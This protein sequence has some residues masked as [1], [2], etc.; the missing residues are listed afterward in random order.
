MILAAL[1]VRIDRNSDPIRA[2]VFA[3]D[4]LVFLPF[5]FGFVT[6][7]DFSRAATPQIKPGFIAPER[8][9]IPA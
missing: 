8:M 7:H 6:G 1:A 5:M 9:S 3:R 2:R 4:P